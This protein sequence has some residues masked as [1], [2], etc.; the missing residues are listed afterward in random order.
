[1]GWGR[2]ISKAS[3]VV[4][5]CALAGLSGCGGGGGSTST[6]A[7]VQACGKVA[8]G[9]ASYHHVI[10]LWMENQDYDSVIGSSSAPYMNSLAAG[11]GLATDYHAITSPSL[12][13][14][15]AATSGVGGDSL[16]RYTSD[17]DPDSQCSTPARSIF[18]EVP[19]WRGYQESMPSPCTRHDDGRYA[20]RHN[21]PPYYT[22]LAGCQ[23]SDLPLSALAGDLNGNSLPA[24]SFITPN[25]CDDAHSCPLHDGDTWLSHELPRIFQSPAYRA[26]QTAL[27]ITFDEGDNGSRV[28]TF[29]ISPSTPAGQRS[30]AAFDHYSL[31]R[32]T[33]DLLGVPPLGNA[34]SADSMAQSFGL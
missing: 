2:A 19:S 17:C 23:Q 16:H 9:S 21:P 25:I 14:Y 20:V 8:P 7:K 4:L 3:A 18:A 30:G 6:A 28:P 22:S 1:M 10:W 13:N 27:F 15:I 32:T 11:C 29:V 12:P 26:G 31:L 33:E 5:L 24:F 34:G